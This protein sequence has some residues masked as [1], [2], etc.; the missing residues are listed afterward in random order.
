SEPV[1]T[2]EQQAAADA[3]VDTPA[4]PAEDAIGELPAV[5]GQPAEQADAAE[6][7]AAADDPADGLPLTS[8]GVAGGPQGAVGPASEIATLDDEQL[9]AVAAA[10][11]RQQERDAAQQQLSEQLRSTGLPAARAESLASGLLN[12]GHASAADAVDALGA[13][14]TRAIA[15]LRAGDTAAASAALTAAERAYAGPLAELVQAR[16]A[17]VAVD[18]ELLFDSL[19]DRPALREHDLDLLASQVDALDRAITGEP[20]AAGHALEL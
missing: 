8:E 19:Q 12:A 11:L 1:E 15:A 9:L 6:G 7:P 2:P 3:G 16:D 20:Q 5:A 13:A 14:V 17:A 10:T 4:A 18:T